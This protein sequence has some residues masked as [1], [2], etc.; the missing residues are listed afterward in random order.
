[1]RNPKGPGRPRG[2]ATARDVP[3]VEVQPASKC[4]RCG[5]PHRA[6]YEHRNVQKYSAALRDG[7]QYDEIIRRRTKCEDCGQARIDREYRF[8]GRTI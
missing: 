7:R 8:R 4:T 2:S 1:V 3:V 6:E 5:S